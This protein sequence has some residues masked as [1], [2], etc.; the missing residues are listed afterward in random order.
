MGRGR[1]PRNPLLQRR[2]PSRRKARLLSRTHP[3]RSI[4]CPCSPRSLRR[5]RPPLQE[6]PHHYRGTPHL[7]NDRR[8]R[9][10]RQGPRRVPQLS[11]LA[12]RYCFARPSPCAGQKNGKATHRRGSV[13]VC[14]ARRTELLRS[15]RMETRRRALATQKRRAAEAPFLNVQTFRAPSRNGKIPP[16]T[17]LVRCL[18]SEEGVTAKRGSPDGQKSICSSWREIS[19]QPR[20]SSLCRRE[21]CSSQSRKAPE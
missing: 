6:R 4:Q 3:L 8:C 5:T 1:S 7:F 18:P 12:S 20:R 10:P 13:Q 19:A 16:R 17:P 21:K 15:L 14:S 2:N 9:R 11:I